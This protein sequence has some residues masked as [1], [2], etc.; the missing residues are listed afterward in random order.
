[1]SYLNINECFSDIK[2]PGN[3]KLLRC[4]CLGDDN[5]IKFLYKYQNQ[6]W[7]SI[8][9]KQLAYNWECIFFLSEK[10][11][12]FVAPKLMQMA[13]SE[14]ESIAEWIEPFLRLLKKNKSLFSGKQRHVIEYF[15]AIDF[16]KYQ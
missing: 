4:D 10:G 14:H 8:E 5:D 11:F 6:D 3:D 13:M 2:H 9:S 12:L 7:F 1:M 16:S 15:L